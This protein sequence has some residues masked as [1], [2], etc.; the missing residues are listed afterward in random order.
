M[1]WQ[2]SEQPW[3][4]AHSNRRMDDRAAFYINLHK[5]DDCLIFFRLI[6]FAIFNTFASLNNSVAWKFISSIFIEKIRIDFWKLTYNKKHSAET[7]SRLFKKSW[8][9]EKIFF[10]QNSHMI[11]I[12]LN[13]QKWVW[14]WRWRYSYIFKMLWQKWILS[15]YLCARIW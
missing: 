4:A 1:Y 9:K 6:I 13:I 14:D 10:F 15:L 3:L 7:N 5:F 8:M 12:S 2:L 11:Q